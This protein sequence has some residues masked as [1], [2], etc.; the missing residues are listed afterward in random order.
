[1]TY[2]QRAHWFFPSW[3]RAF[4][5]NWFRDRGCILPLE[6]RPESEWLQQVEAAAR[7]LAF[8]QHRAETEEIYRHACAVVALGRN[9]SSQ[10]MTNDQLDL[11]ECLF[12]L[13]TNPLDLEAVLDWQN[14]D[15]MASRRLIGGIERMKP[16]AYVATMS[17]NIYGSRE[18]RLLS[19]PQLRNLSKL[20]WRQS[21][22]AGN[23]RNS[24]VPQSYVRRKSN[25]DF[26]P[27]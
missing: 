18:W 3:Q 15:R 9:I 1:M 19:V 25:P 16:D 12:R 23:P 11:V 20:L 4:R 26:E 6:S 13:L 7:D 17:S 8:H 21:V 10:D 14:P 24:R 5:A 2:S 27:F 22:R